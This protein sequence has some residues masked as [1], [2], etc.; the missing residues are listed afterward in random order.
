V[1]ILV[2]YEDGAEVEAEEGNQV[3]KDV[4]N[5]DV[6]EVGVDVEELKLGN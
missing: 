6:A 3:G 4:G 2:G 1:G 5:T